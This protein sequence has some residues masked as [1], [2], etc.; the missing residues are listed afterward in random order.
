[1]PK[2]GLN[3][4]SKT[5]DRHELT[6]V[7]SHQHVWD[8][9]QFRLPW[10]SEVEALNR[11][12]RSEDYRAAVETLPVVKSIYLEVDVDPEQQVAEAIAAIKLCRNPD[13]LT[14]GAVISG[15]PASEGF[16]DYLDRFAES[17]EIKGLRQVLHGT[18]TPRGYCLTPEFIAGVQDL[19]DHGLSFDIC[20]RA[21]ELED[22][23][24]LVAECPNTLFI[25]DHL[26]NASLKMSGAEID[27]W[28][29]A[30]SMLSGR[31]NL[32]TKISGIIATSAGRKWSAEEIAPFI[33][34][35]LSEFGPDRVLFG[36]D[37]PVCNLGGSLRVWVENLLLTVAN[38]DF[39]DR[40]KLFTENAIR[41]YRI[42]R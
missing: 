13:T 3:D 28:R 25:L 6:I 37:W 21:S 7:D 23:D 30:I 35:V 33:D 11:S 8:L 17:P 41:I 9:G 34:H 15:R 36:G 42:E 32:V 10:L 14:V 31:P 20:I 39:R 27:A 4:Y 12:F 5:L 1:M 24:R 40:Q 38:Q 19:G 22:A 26:G 2:G 29:K 18:S 16:H